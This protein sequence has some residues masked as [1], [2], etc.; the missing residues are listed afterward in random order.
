MNEVNPESD[1]RPL[2]AAEKHTAMF[3]QMVMQSTSMAMMWLGRAP[4]PVSGNTEKDLDAARMFIDQLEMLELKTRGNLSREE[5]QFLNQNLMNVR[6][7][8]VEAVK[9]PSDQPAVGEQKPQAPGAGP[10][11]EPASGVENPKRRF[12]KSYGAD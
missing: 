9:Q 5:Q 4:N 10:A 12:T 7:A 8:F 2:T 6:M 11:V 1:A 3:A